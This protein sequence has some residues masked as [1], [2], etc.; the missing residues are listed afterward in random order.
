MD[1]IGAIEIFAFVTGIIY[2][3]LEIGQKNFM[4]ILGI[5]TG[6]ACAWSFGVQ[7]LYAS[8][9]LNIYYVYVSVWGLIQWRKDSRA[10]EGAIHLNR[11]TAGT[12]L[13]SGVVFVAG[14]ALLICLLE[15]LGGS[16]SWFDAATAMLSAVGTWWLA[17]S[18][19]QQWIVWIVADVMSVVLCAVS[20]MPWMTVLYVAYTAGAVY[21]YIHWLRSGKYIEQ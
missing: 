2:I 15:L 7:G 11:L 17:K 12:L 21:G 5:L 3:V 9:G 4:W 1:I 19:P 8:M 6:A 20:G 14:T 16:E 13:A 18:Y 10:S